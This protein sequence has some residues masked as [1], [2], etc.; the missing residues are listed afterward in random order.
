M[1]ERGAFPHL[2]IAR[3]ARGDRRKGHSIQPHFTAARSLP[4][5]RTVKIAVASPLAGGGAAGV[6]A[7]GAITRAGGSVCLLLV[8]VIGSTLALLWVC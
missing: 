5:A 8:T 3:T 6:L 4:C 2:Q 1:E 7:P